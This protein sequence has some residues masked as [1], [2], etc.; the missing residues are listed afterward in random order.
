M[1]ERPPGGGLH[2]VGKMLTCPECGSPVSELAA[3][4]PKCGRP[5]AAIRPTVP[6]PPVSDSAP[7]SQAA[8]GCLSAL[9]LAVVIGL[10][11]FFVIGSHGAP[12][13]TPV[14]HRITGTLELADTSAYGN[15]ILAV[16]GSCWGTGG[17]SDITAGATVTLTDEAGT[18]LAST[19]LGEGSGTAS[20]CTFDFTLEGVPDTAK[21][22][23]VQV[24]R[25]GQVT[26]SH[27]DMVADGWTFALTLGD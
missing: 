22:Y 3:A 18:I 26:N 14:L 21:F 23:S 20:L 11:A 7:R 12:T 2:E 13:P 10:G 27:A 16:G 8:L 9:V 4:C 15:G 6:P 5:A 25:R 17:Y 1:W 19:S 24:S